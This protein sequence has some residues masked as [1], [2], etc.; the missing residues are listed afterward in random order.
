MRITII[1]YFYRWEFLTANSSNLI[2]LKKYAFSLL[3]MLHFNFRHSITLTK[4]CS[5]TEN[6][7]ELMSIY[8][9]IIKYFTTNTYKKANFWTYYSLAPRLEL[10]RK[11]CRVQ[12]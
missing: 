6:D 8:F 10:L 1:I 3:E 5:I 11:E 12:T 2:V 9:D 4:N 7:I